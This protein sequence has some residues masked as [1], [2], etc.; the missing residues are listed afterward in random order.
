LIYLSKKYFFLLVFIVF[1]SAQNLKI[2]ESLQNGIYDLYSYN[3]S[4]STKH[5]NTVL[6]LDRSNSIAP[7]LLI[8][9]D[10]LMNQTEFGYNESY[11]AI[12][13]G[14]KN[15]IPKYKALISDYPNK[16]EYYLFLGS[17]YGLKARV[18][19]ASK[20]WL[21]VLYSGY[22]GIKYIKEAQKIDSTLYD[23][24]L[25]IGL[26]EY[27]LCISS[28]PIQF[29]GKVMG[30]KC[31]CEIGKENLELALKESKYAWIESANIL[32]YIYLYFE[33]DYDN[34]LRTSSLLVDNFPDHPLF[35]F[36]K[37]ESLAKNN[38]WDEVNKI[39]PK[40]EQIVKNNKHLLKNEVELKLK[41][42]YVLRAFNNENYNYVIQE[43]NWMI[44]NYKM[45]FDW[46]LGFAYMIRGK[47]FDKLGMNEMALKDYKSVLK[48]NNYFPEIEEAKKIIKTR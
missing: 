11:E 7:F 5:L 8:V 23:V 13:S 9:N 15:T 25:S 12:I 22:A 35:I 29:V 34:A 16:A 27:F 43:T 37:A 6:K 40:L 30:F 21:D 36:L 32:S 24:N 38:M 26:L 19:L 4:S 41:H 18:S 42:I 47:T 1:S 10:W 31:D 17:T 44:E 14:V 33:R 39:L 28:V 20:D 46:L 48:L 45:E 3:F 2:N